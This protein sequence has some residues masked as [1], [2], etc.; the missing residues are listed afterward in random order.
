MQLR[1]YRVW[2]LM[3]T[4]ERTGLVSLLTFTLWRNVQLVLGITH[5]F[6]CLFYFMADYQFYSDFVHLPDGDPALA[7][8]AEDAAWF[9]LTPAELRGWNTYE[10]YGRSL[11][12][13]VTTL[14]TV[15]YGDFSPVTVGE[16]IFVTVRPRPAPRSLHACHLRCKRCAVPLAPCLVLPRRRWWPP[17]CQ[18]RAVLLWLNPCTHACLHACA[19][20]V[21]AAVYVAGVL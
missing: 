9:Q 5:L 4:L 18:R 21:S 13:S 6:A 15:G 11:Y 14:T 1:L 3:W 20:D 19:V 7:A 10:R 16:Q 12:W 8:D 2:R 17:R